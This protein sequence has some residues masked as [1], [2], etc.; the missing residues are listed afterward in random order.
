MDYDR[1]E[2]QITWLLDRVVAPILILLIILVG[3]SQYMIAI[4]GKP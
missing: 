3:I 1:I 2:K 4:G